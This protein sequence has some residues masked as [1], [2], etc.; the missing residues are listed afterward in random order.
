MWITSRSVLVQEIFQNV[1]S[2]KNI[3]PIPTVYLE[4][5][6]TLSTLLST[7]PKSCLILFRIFS[8]IGANFKDFIHALTCLWAY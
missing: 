7:S 6:Q 4:S 3:I 5:I 1:S 8:K 2:P